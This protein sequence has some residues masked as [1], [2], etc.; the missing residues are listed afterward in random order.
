MRTAQGVV[1]EIT[2]GN[3]ARVVDDAGKVLYYPISPENL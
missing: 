2:R 3:H 1:T